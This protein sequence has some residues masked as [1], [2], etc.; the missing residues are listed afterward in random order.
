MK[1]L[2]AA[3]YLIAKY[4]LFS[5]NTV[6][7]LVVSLALITTGCSKK[8]SETDRSVVASVSTN[9]QQKLYNLKIG[10]I[11]IGN[12]LEQEQTIKALKEY[13]DHSV[14]E[15]VD[16]EAQSKTIGRQATQN[17]QETQKRQNAIAT[18]LNF[19]IGKD[20]N[21]VVD[22]LVQGKLD[23]AYLGPMSYLEAVDRGAKIEP[24]VAAIDKYTGQPW[25]RAC[26][27][28]KQDSPIQTLQNLKGKRIAFVDKLSTSGYLMPLATLKKLGID[29]NRDFAQAL[30]VG[31][32]SKSIAVLE[33]GI[34]DA[35]AVN[36]SYYSKQQ[37]KHKLK[38]Q[39]SRILWKSAPIPNFLI[40]TSKKLPSEV[41][42]QLKH[43]FLS[44]PEG[45]DDIIGI[46][47]AGYTL[48]SHS[49]YASI[50]QLRKDLNLISV[51]AK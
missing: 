8:L 37:K 20:Y 29:P 18:S 36:L 21:E 16:I 49:D 17:S 2:L 19:Q 12:Q 15:E 46:E 25:Y 30:Y 31:S 11:P 26:I 48:V 28:V 45:L 50:E 38:S 35:A 32:Y 27:I 13:L 39:H 42:Q 40:V 14:R 5:K 10:V 34:V 6:L 24:L 47:S 9:N 7:I 51:P 4:A 1:K 23:M 44:S 3:P 43:A 41:V 22:W 33:D